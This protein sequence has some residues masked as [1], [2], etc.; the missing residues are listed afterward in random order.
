M[1][2]ER[3]FTLIELLIVVAIIAALAGILLPVY[4]R[5]RREA[6]AATCVSNIKQIGAALLMYAQDWN[7]CA[8]PYFTGTVETIARDSGEE[9]PAVIDLTS[10]NSP[11]KLKQCFAPYGAGSDAL[12]VCPLDPHDPN[13]VVLHD[14]TVSYRVS[15]IFATRRP[16]RLD[17]PPVVSVEEYARM[18]SSGEQPY[19]FTWVR[20]DDV[21][22]PRPYYLVCCSVHSGG[23]DGFSTVPHGR[24]YPVLRLDGSVT[25]KG[26]EPAHSPYGDWGGD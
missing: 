8:P 17:S 25:F 18:L 4:A 12:W 24:S 1:R 13:R 11:G 20:S 7:G 22:M 26:A 15:P 9:K 6:M 23:R 5:S 21:Q 14:P 19:D 3:A 2:R 16:V 10:L